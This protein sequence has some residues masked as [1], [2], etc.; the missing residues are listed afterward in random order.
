MSVPGGGGRGQELHEQRGRGCQRGGDPTLTLVTSHIETTATCSFHA[1]VDLPPTWTEG[2]AHW[3]T[4]DR[5]STY[6][7]S[8]KFYE[9]AFY[10]STVWLVLSCYVHDSTYWKYCFLRCWISTEYCFVL[11]SR[12]IFLQN[13]PSRRTYIAIFRPSQMSPV[14]LLLTTGRC[15]VCCLWIKITTGLVQLDWKQMKNDVTRLAS[16]NETEPE[17]YYAWPSSHT[18]VHTRSSDKSSVLH[19]VV[20]SSVFSLLQAANSFLLL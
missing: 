5:I 9:E 11:I 15:Y 3:Q 7:F 10:K 1:C 4:A 6:S 8:E 17:H 12:P 13:S 16:H 20:P 2:R 19:S 18:C 14:Y